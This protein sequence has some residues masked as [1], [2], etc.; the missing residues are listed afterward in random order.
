MQPLPS[1]ASS[2]YCAEDAD[3]MASWDAG[4]A[5]VLPSSP[6]PL[7]TTVLIFPPSLRDPDRPISDLFTAEV[8]QMPGTDYVARFQDGSL[9]CATRLNAIDWILK[10]ITHFTPDSP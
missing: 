5:W 8:E 10:A 1:L 2:L 3:D 4:D 9:D 7:P 6:S